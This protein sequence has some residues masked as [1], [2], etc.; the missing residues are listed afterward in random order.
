MANPTTER[1]SLLDPK[2]LRKLLE[3]IPLRAIAEDAEARRIVSDEASDSAQREI[4]SLARD[5]PSDEDQLKLGA[6]LSSARVV[7]TQGTA[8][9]VFRDKEKFVVVRGKLGTSLGRSRYNRCR[10]A[11]G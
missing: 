9:A 2:G 5:Q 11:V 6:G 8:Y 10:V 4:T 7:G 3:A 1:N